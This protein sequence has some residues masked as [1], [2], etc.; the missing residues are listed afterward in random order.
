MFFVGHPPDFRFP[1][2]RRLRPIRWRAGEDPEF[3]VALQF[4]R[5]GGHDDSLW[6]LDAHGRRRWIWTPRIDLADFDGRPF[7]PVWSITDMTTD[8]TGG[9]GR[10]WVAVANPLRWASALYRLGRDGRATLQFG[11]AGSILQVMRLPE[12]QQSRLIISGVNNAFSRAFVAEIDPDGPAGFSPPSGRPR[13][14]FQQALP[15]T[16]KRYIQLAASELHDAGRVP[17]FAAH[18]SG[19][20]ADQVVVDT[21]ELAQGKTVYNYFFASDLTPIRARVAASGIGLHRFYEAEGALQHG[22][23]QCPELN[24]PLVVRIWEPQRGWREAVI[25]VSSQ[26][27][28]N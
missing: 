12:R 2:S 3:V 27:N 13:Y 7:E 10:I 4:V 8:E 14:R 22:A 28:S 1:W 26:L 15:G 17:Y 21:I 5:E 20:T 9:Q 6:L 24:Q 19:L 23:E 16:A 11:N 25:P 18:I